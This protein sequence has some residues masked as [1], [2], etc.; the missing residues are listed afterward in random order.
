MHWIGIDVSKAT[1]D[2]ALSDDQGRILHEQQIA[3]T[4]RAIKGLL[5]RWLK[6]YSPRSPQGEPERRP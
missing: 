4:D 5:N 2:L 1:L 3:N 6:K